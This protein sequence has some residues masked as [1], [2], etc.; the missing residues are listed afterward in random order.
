MDVIIP[1]QDK[2]SIPNKCCV[3]GASNPVS[4]FQ[5]KSKEV[6]HFATTASVTMTF[7]K[8][9][10]CI[11]ELKAIKKTEKPTML[12]GGAIGLLIG[13]GIGSF[14]FLTSGGTS[15]AQTD[16]L[17]EIL[18]PLC[19][20]GGIFGLMGLLVAKAVWSIKLG[21]TT[22]QKIKVLEFPVNILDFGFQTGFL[23][24]VK[25]AVVKINFHN[26]VFC[27]EFMALNNFRLV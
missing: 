3:C 10:S 15:T 6:R 7:L 13:I 11:D 2:Y 5:I 19:A 20:V 16:L 22:R 26:E 21:S 24:N 9:Q 14:I 1:Y 17:N 25:S 12:V 27:Q 23:G 18:G 4:E 8:C